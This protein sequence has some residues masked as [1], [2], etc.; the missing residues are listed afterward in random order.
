MSQIEVA[1]DRVVARLRAIANARRR[2]TEFRYGV[3]AP[4]NL[5]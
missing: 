4:D 2:L 1:S 5:N 3:G